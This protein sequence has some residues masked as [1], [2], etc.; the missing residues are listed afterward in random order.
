MNLLTQ[1][2]EPLLVNEQ[3]TYCSYISKGKNDKNVVSKYTN[4]QSLGSDR[5]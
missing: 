4:Q 1:T 5:F 3:H 2:K